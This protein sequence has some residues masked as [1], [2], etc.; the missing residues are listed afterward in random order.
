M[1]SAQE[2]ADKFSRRA[3][4]LEK[5]LEKGLKTIALKV[6]RAQADNLRGGV[7]AGDYPVPVRSANL[8]RNRF[9]SVV[10][11]RYAIMG[12]K[13]AHAT[14]V[15]AGTGPNLIHGPREFLEDAVESVVPG[16]EMKKETDKVW[17]I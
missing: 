5:A 9:F 11:S 14:S 4:L 12:N 7:N 15:H 8:L 3:A 2:L 10:G 17:A 6:D 13:S 16:V 1:S